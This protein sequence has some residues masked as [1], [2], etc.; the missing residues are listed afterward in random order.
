MQTPAA[1]LRQTKPMLAEEISGSM[2]DEGLLMISK[3]RRLRRRGAEQTQFRCHEMVGTAHPTAWCRTGGAKQSQF[4]TVAG[5]RGAG[6]QWRQT[7][8]M[9]PAV[10]PQGHPEQCLTASLRTQDTKHPCSRADGA[11]QSQFL[12]GAGRSP[13]REPRATNKANLTSRD[14]SAALRFG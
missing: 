1:G 10:G 14:L 3:R 2:M 8:P 13:P 9:W 11:K 12:A 5:G 4:A 7:K 6:G